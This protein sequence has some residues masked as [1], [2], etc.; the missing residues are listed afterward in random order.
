MG[1]FGKAKQQRA[2]NCMD[3]VDAFGA[4]IERLATTGRQ[5]HSLDE[6]PFEKP[7]IEAALLTLAVRGNTSASES[8]L[9]AGYVELSAFQEGKSGI[10]VD[11]PGPPPST[12]EEIAK[13][14]RDKAPNMSAQSKELEG[15]IKESAER[16]QEWDQ[17]LASMKG[18][19]DA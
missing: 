8:M 14:M 11:M 6:L 5:T 10:S 3:V 7:L 2:I 12:R 15:V 1:I 18:S 4:T 19:P 16:S 17:R 13:F 9:K